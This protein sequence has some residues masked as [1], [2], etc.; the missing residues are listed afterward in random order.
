MCRVDFSE[1]NILTWTALDET[2]PLDPTGQRLPRPSP[3]HKVNQL[4]CTYVS[5]IPGQ[6]NSSKQAMSRS[7][8]C[9]RCAHEKTVSLPVLSWGLI[10]FRIHQWLT[11]KAFNPDKTTDILHFWKIIIIMFYFWESV[12]VRVGRLRK[13]ESERERERERETPQS[14][15]SLLRAGSH[16]STWAKFKNHLLNP[17]SHPGAYERLFLIQYT[18]KTWDIRFQA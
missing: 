16:G 3:M 17:P 2:H 9:Y 12:H 7:A 6:W 8:T 11:L 18:D 10:G 13:R 1:L 15:Q 14:T 4:I 5:W